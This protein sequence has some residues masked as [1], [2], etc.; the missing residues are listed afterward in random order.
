VESIAFA[1]DARMQQALATNSVDIVLG[2][3]PAMA[4]IVKVCLCF[5]NNPLRMPMSSGVN[6]K[7]SGTALP[8]RSFSAA[9]AGSVDIAMVSPA[10]LST[11]RAMAFNWSP[12]S[13]PG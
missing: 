4:C 9:E 10:V 7:A 6:E 8:T 11:A 13:V 1:G 2:S 3:G 12:A 5:A